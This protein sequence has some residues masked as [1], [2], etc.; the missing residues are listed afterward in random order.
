MGEL[1]FQVRLQNTNELS[2]LADACNEHQTQTFESYARFQLQKN[3]HN[4][5]ARTELGFLLWK[6][7]QI[8]SAV[9]EFRTAAGD[10]PSYDQPHY[11]LGVICRAQ[12]RLTDAQTEFATAIR[13]NPSNSRAFGNLGFVYLALGNIEEAEANLMQALKLNPAD[14]LARSTLQEIRRARQNPTTPK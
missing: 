9:Q 12:K 10:D 13:L 8:M 5:Q 3:P 1:W 2:Q 7:G 6:H 4:A 14:E 11:Y